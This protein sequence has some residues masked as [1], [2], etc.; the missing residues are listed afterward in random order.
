M[1]VAKIGLILSRTLCP[2]TIFTDYYED[3]IE[4]LSARLV[5][6]ART[7]MG[8]TESA[9]KLTGMSNLSA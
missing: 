3:F 1:P 4:A 9:V 7:V 5:Q 8:I 2:E 6:E